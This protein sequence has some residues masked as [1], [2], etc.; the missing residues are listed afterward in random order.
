MRSSDYL[1][2]P[3]WAMLSRTFSSVS[4][5]RRLLR[6]FH[7]HI[8]LQNDDDWSQGFPCATE[9]QHHLL[10][11]IAEGCSCCIK[12]TGPSPHHYFLKYMKPILTIPNL[13]LLHTEENKRH[14]LLYCSHFCQPHK[15]TK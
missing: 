13:F 12:M 10:C 8:L 14:N 4:F 15:T 3:A 7:P 1:E 6:F 2:S 5:L 9:I 11:L